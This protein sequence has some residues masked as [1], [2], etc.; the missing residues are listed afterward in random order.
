MRILARQGVPTRCYLLSQTDLPT[1]RHLRT[2]GATQRSIAERY[3]VSRHTVARYLVR[4]GV[5]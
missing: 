5:E 1:I 3:G 2:Q 4:F